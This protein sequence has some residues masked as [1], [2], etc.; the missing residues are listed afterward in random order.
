MVEEQLE[1]FKKHIALKRYQSYFNSWLYD[2]IYIF[3]TDYN[4]VLSNTS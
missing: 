2:I 4:S 1:E 3:Q